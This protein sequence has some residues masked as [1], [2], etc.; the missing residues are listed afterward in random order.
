MEMEAIVTVDGKETKY[1]H[2]MVDLSIATENSPRNAGAWTVDK[3]V[4]IITSSAD[5]GVLEANWKSL[6]PHIGK[7]SGQDKSLAQKAHD[8]TK[9]FIEEA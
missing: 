6:L 9:R 7:L 1:G 2:E 3:I 8:D 4:D 5:L